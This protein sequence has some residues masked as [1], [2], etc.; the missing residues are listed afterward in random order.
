MMGNEKSRILFV[1]MGNICR[2]PIVET[3]ARVELARAGIAAEVASAGTERYHIGERADPRAIEIA[4][5]NDYPLAQHR[6]R[7]VAPGDFSRFDLVLAMDRVNLD[8]L[9]RHRPREGRA[10]FLF[11]E[12]VGFDEI[13]EVPDPYYGSR[14]DFERV[15]DLARR[16]TRLLIERLRAP[17]RA[18]A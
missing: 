9:G 10:P 12:H 8:A 11:L 3:V 17:E 2:S 15:L 5:A 13:D 14:R 4:E 1:C 16:G 18:R 7:Q 6:A